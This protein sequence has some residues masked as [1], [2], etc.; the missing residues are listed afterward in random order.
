MYFFQTPAVAVKT[1]F[2]LPFRVQLLKIFLTSK[3]FQEL[4]DQSKQMS[5]ALNDI[6]HWH[7]NDST[8][9]LNFILFF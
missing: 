3:Q 7:K 4:V 2:H 5:S 8:K 1:P 6:S 9:V